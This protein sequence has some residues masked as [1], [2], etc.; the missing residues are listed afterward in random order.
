M[1]WGNAGHHRVEQD[2]VIEHLHTML[3]TFVAML[4][5][6]NVIMDIFV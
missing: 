6:F 5:I 4:D 1:F 2:Q 3:D